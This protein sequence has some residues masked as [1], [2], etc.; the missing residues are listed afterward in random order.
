MTVL[1]RKDIQEVFPAPGFS[2]STYIQN[3]KYCICYWLQT[4]GTFSISC[5]CCTSL[6]TEDRQTYLHWRI[7]SGMTRFIFLSYN[8]RPLIVFK[9]IHQFSS[10]QFISV[11]QSCLTLCNPMNHSTPGLPVH[12]HFPEFTQTHIQTYP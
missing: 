11:A 2:P 5:P 12:C 3:E 9:H 7:F 6:F 8:Y 1:I 10:V 4:K